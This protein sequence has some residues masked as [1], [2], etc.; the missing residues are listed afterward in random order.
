MAR[1]VGEVKCLE[2]G[3]TAGVFADKRNWLYT[4][5]KADFGGDDCGI[6]K[7]QSAK[8]Q[9]R[10]RARWARERPEQAAQ[11]L[12]PAPKPEPVQEPAP[13]TET[14]KPAPKPAEPAPAPAA[15]KAPKKPGIFGK[16]RKAVT[17]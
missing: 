13:V 15:K 4:N 1:H 9:A 14:P 16:S 11:F 5:C 7:Y 10:I 12:G 6:N 2:C 3:G 8:G 17:A